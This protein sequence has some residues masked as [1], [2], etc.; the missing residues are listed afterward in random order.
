MT[1]EGQSIGLFA[2]LLGA[3]AI[4]LFFGGWLGYLYALVGFA[5]IMA[6]LNCRELLVRMR[7]WR[8]ARK[9]TELRKAA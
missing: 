6:F 4:I 7:D 5:I 3:L 2:L 1:P 8:A 9:S